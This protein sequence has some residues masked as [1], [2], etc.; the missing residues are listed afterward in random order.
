MKPELTRHS[1][2]RLK[3]R[4]GANKSSQ[5][6]IAT[7][8][9]EK[10]IKHAETSGSLRRYLDMLYLQERNANNIRIWGDKVFLFRADRLITVLQLPQKYMKVCSRIRE[11]EEAP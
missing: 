8:A 1:K 9:L 11:R 4:C 7:T 2:T 10:G 5:E 3:E 6:K